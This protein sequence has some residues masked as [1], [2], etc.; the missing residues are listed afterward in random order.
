MSSNISSV[1]KDRTNRTTKSRD[2]FEGISFP[3]G[4]EIKNDYRS[5]ITC[6]R[7]PTQDVKKQHKTNIIRPMV[8]SFSEPWRNNLIK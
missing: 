1:C 7:T 2:Y 3:D 4:K 6:T 5:V 8:I